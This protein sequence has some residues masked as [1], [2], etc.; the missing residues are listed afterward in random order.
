MKLGAVDVFIW[1]VGQVLQVA[2]FVCVL[3][4]RS[5]G[6]YLSLAVYSLSGFAGS[7]GLYLIGLRSG[8]QSREYF[9]AYYYCDAVLAI[10]LYFIVIAF[11]EQVFLELQVS[12]YIRGGATFLLIATAFFSYAIVHEHKDNLTPRFAVELEQNLNFVGVVLVYLLWGAVLKLRETRIR[13]V[14]LILALGIYF[15]GIT[16]VYAA[17]NLFPVLVSSSF[18]WA[19]PLVALWL[20]A[21][22]AY[23]FIKVPDERRLQIAQL[24]P[25]AAS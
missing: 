5:C 8:I 6:R 22:W 3:Y 25:K 17:D 23:S 18:K 7:M 1:I 20:P 11:Y 24:A 13:L 21:A 10:L 9:Y 16:I 14:Q 12:R 19:P 2:V 15:S 4:R